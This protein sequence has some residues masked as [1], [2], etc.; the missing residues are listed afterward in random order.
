MRPR[1]VDFIQGRLPG[2]NWGAIYRYRDRATREH[3]R[4]LIQGRAAILYALAGRVV[5]VSY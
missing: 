1:R 5:L 3:D 4:P 2:M